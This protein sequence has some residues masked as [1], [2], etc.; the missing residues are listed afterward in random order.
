MKTHRLIIVLTVLAAVTAAYLHAAPTTG[1]TTVGVVDVTGVFQAS[2]EWAAIKVEFDRAAVDDKAK[3]E[4]IDKELKKLNFNLEQLIDPKK[5]PQEY[6]ATQLKLR[7]ML[8]ERNVASQFRKA[9]AARR[10]ILRNHALYNKF[11]KICGK[12]SLEIGL[13]L[14]L[15]KESEKLAPIKN[16]TQLLNQIGSRKVIWSAPELDITDLVIETL[17]ANWDGRLR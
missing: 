14:V 4:E 1:P 9:E 6:E 7:K 8:V 13:Q 17:N 16:H 5:N 15:F 2:Q 10:I 3:L 11:A 12:L